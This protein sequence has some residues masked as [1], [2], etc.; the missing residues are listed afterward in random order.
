MLPTLQT[1]TDGGVLSEKKGEIWKIAAKTEIVSDRSEP[2]VL[3]NVPLITRKPSA[4]QWVSHYHANLGQT[5][6]VTDNEERRVENNIAW[7]GDGGGTK[8][9]CHE[10]RV[11]WRWYR[12]VWSLTIGEHG[13]VCSDKGESPD[14]DSSGWAFLARSIEI[15][16][17]RV[18]HKDLDCMSDQR[19]LQSTWNTVIPLDFYP[20]EE[21]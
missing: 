2:L 21:G 8:A 17:T 10:F 4:N 9:E 5:S 1:F 7:P 14:I 18:Q 19:K 12:R 15:P 16:R 11:A 13:P 6:N 20:L 3:E